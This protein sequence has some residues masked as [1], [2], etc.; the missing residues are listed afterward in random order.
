MLKRLIG[1]VL[2]AAGLF[3]WSGPADAGALLKRVN[4]SA[5]VPLQVGH[6]ARGDADARSV[7]LVAAR[8]REVRHDRRYSARRCM[9]EGVEGDEHLHDAVRHRGGRRLHD[10]DVGLTH[11]LVDLHEDVLVGELH[12]V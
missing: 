12:H 3:A 4:L 10:E 1:I 9:L 6:Q 11:V 7:L 8:V 2:V 5:F